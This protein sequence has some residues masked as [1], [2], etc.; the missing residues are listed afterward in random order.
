MSRLLPVASWTRTPRPPHCQREASMAVPS[1]TVRDVRR[2]VRDRRVTPCLSSPVAVSYCRQR[3]R[4]RCSRRGPGLRCR[5]AWRPHDVLAP[6]QPS[7]SAA[8]IQPQRR[9][10]TRGTP[11]PRPSRGCQAQ[12]LRPATASPA[13]C[14]AANA[15]AVRTATATALTSTHQPRRGPCREG[16]VGDVC[17]RLH[18][19]VNRCLTLLMW[20]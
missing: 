2:L 10:R 12:R 1:G 13:S 4:R 5:R 17:G 20:W 6:A 16:P 14:T 15:D 19:D 7:G 3:C 11:T 8:P 9:P 18:L